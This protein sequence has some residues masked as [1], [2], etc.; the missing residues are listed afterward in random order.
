[1]ANRRCKSNLVESHQF[2]MEAKCEANR[3]RHTIEDREAGLHFLNH[4]L[5]VISP[6]FLVVVVVVVV[7]LLFLLLLPLLLTFL[8]LP[9]LHFIFIHEC[10]EQGKI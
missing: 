7:V 4:F 9:A 3:A 5:F 1:M 2:S 10:T 6:L 8:Y